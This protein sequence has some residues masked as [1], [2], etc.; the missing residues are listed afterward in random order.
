MLT[1]FFIRVLNRDKTGFAESEQLRPVLETVSHSFDV[2]LKDASDYH[3]L[4]KISDQV[5]EAIEKSDVVFADANS[6]NENV[7]Y[8]IGYAD[9]TNAKKVICL[10]IRGR[11][12]PFDRTDMRSIQYDPS[13]QG[14]MALEAQLTKML[15]DLLCDKRL[16]EILTRAEGPQLVTHY[17]SSKRL[18]A[19]G[20]EWLMARVRDTHEVEALRIASL[21]AIGALG[22][23]DVSL[24]LELFNPTVESPKVM[25]AAYEQAGDSD[26]PLPETTWIPFPELTSQSFLRE[27]YAT[28]LIKQWLKGHLPESRVRELI[29]D[30]RIRLSILMAMQRAFET[31]PAA[32][33][34]E[35]DGPK[36]A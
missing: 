2:L 34:V 8:E 1:A 35:S 28:A 9:R 26:E 14:L 3:S 23:V 24:L 21:K 7:W 27:A 6:A 22:A 11:V 5:T 20:I 18:R 25:T 13:E 30:G 17:L 32:W 16:R 29:A 19:L 36:P 12:L 33:P 15:M 31:V 10:Y 4:G